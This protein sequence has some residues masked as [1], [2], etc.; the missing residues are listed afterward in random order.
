L[1]LRRWIL[2]FRCLKPLFFSAW[3]SGLVWGMGWVESHLIC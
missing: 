2:E 3:R 1:V